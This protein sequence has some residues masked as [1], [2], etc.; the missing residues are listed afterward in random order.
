M[1]SKLWL[2][3]AILT[4]AIFISCNGGSD[5]FKEKKNFDKNASYAL[6]LNVGASLLD[7]LNASKVYPDLNELLKGISDGLKAK[8]ARYTLEEAREMISAAIEII[9]EQEAAR[10]IKEETEFL[11]ENAKKPGITITPSGLQ[12]EVIRPGSGPNPSYEDSVLAHYE[13]TFISGKF[14]DS[15]YT[16]GTPEK[17][18]LDEIIPGWTEGLQLMSVGSKYKFYIPSDIGYGEEGAR[19]Y[20]TGEYI[21]PPYSTLIFE[22]ELLE[23]NPK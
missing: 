2:F 19:N 12:Y 21:I 14:F 4:T 11:A 17:F 18:K 9:G 15:S 1:K 16:K 6:G 7:D 8:K 20:M 3:I 13:G 10:A 23:I 22:V 5:S